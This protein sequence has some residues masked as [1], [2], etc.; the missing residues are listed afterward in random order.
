[1][2]LSRIPPGM[3]YYVGAEARLRR[4]VE[5]VAM[6]V[7]SRWSYEEI[8]TPA[9]DYYPL[10]EHGMGVKEAQRSFRFTDNDGR[11]LALRPDVTSTVA[12]AAA[13]LLID[14][15]RP[16]RLCYAAPVF[17]QQYHSSAEWRR[18]S[19]QL[20]CELI[21]D[22]S[23]SADMEVLL[24]AAA[25]LKQIGLANRY[26]ITINDVEIFNGLAEQFSLNEVERE[27]IRRLI[28]SRAAPE[29]NSCLA[30][31]NQRTVFSDLIHLRG[32]GDVLTRALRL[33]S[34]VRSMAGLSRLTDIWQAIEA[35]GLSDVFEIDLG[36]VS[37]LDYYTGLNFKVFVNG[38]G[39]RVGGGGR[40]DRLIENFGAAEPAVGFML[41]LDGLVDVLSSAESTIGFK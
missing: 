16:L 9:V 25:V 7:F 28:D 23:V 41:S 24:L 32:K 2:H 11:M 27:E 37:N 14:A 22:G 20:G 29:V 34:N 5:D 33:N 21:G 3:R 26:C 30:D 12:R 13:T 17:K 39:S 1:M 31:L 19:T 8:T 38:A 18:E 15:D 6:F 4:K 10:F 36:D 40:Y 35:N